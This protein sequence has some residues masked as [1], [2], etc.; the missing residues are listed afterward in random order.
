MR[1]AQ[2]TAC[3]VGVAHGAFFANL[4]QRFPGAADY[5]EVAFEEF[6][7]KPNILDW[8]SSIPIIAHCSSLSLAGDVDLDPR[9][10]KQIEE[11]VAQAGSPWLGEH[12]AF[13]T[14]TNEE[15]V[16]DL[17]HTSCPQ[18]SQEILDRIITS[19]SK[20]AS[21]FQTP[22][23]LENP[24]IYYHVP[25]STMSVSEFFTEL[26]HKSK[27]NILLDVAHLFV[28]ARNLGLDE[29]EFAEQFPLER[30]TEMHISGACLQGGILWDDH[31]TPAPREILD[32]LEFV[33]RRA[34]PQAIT[35]EYNWH[36]AFPVD[37]LAK[38]IADVRQIAW[39]A[40][41]ECLAP[42]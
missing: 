25:G 33:L 11:F 16:L 18:L 34:R 41:L 2:T 6:L 32:L 38:E 5:L 35:L 3:R 26:C 22:L 7:A 19:A 10:F 13:V 4:I 17:K 20:Y 37:A 8:K 29:K 15:D 9:T 14:S 1:L 31:A 28:T 24:A 27:I 39:R 42:S 12:V 21:A 40:E 23:L 30:V 36:S